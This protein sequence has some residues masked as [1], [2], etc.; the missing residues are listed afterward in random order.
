MIGE[1]VLVSGLD[2]GEVGDYEGYDLVE[3]VLEIGTFG[4][5]GLD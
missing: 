1:E 3:M 4:A 2:L 5:V